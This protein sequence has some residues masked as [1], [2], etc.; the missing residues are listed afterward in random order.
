MTDQM[1]K[2]KFLD[3][4]LSSLFWASGWC[5]SLGGMAADVGGKMTNLGFRETWCE[6]YMNHR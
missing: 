2:E 4:S 1:A 3:K 6:V 5:N